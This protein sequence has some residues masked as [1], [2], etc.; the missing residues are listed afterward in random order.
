MQT[1]C[2]KLSTHLSRLFPPTTRKRDLT[3]NRAHVLFLCFCASKVAKTCCDGYA[4]LRDSCHVFRP[5]RSQHACETFCSQLKLLFTLL[6]VLKMQAQ[7][8]GCQT[9]HKHLVSLVILAVMPGPVSG[10][11]HCLDRKRKL[12]RHWLTLE[13]N[14]SGKCHLHS[15][16]N[17]EGLCFF[18][19]GCFI[20]IE[21]IQSENVAFHKAP[22]DPLWL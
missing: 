17:L 5:R 3:C 12:S 4:M 13:W 9:M 22:S 19:C 8:Q 2:K 15:T 16:A 21:K 20:P 14:V 18:D 11:G 10:T 6:K 7:R 1:S